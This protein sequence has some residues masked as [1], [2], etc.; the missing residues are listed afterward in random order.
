MDNKNQPAFPVLELKQMGDK[1]LLDC[2]EVG[3]SKLEFFACNAPMDIPSWFEH[4]KPER[5]AINPPLLEN[6]ISESDRKTAEG[7][8]YD[9]IFDLPEHLAW[10]QEQYNKYWAAQRKFHVAN[11]Q[12]R[13]FQWR[14]FY[15]EQLLSELSN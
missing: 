5:E 14:R 4:V 10:F 2:A 7:W 3:V 9:P 8:L 6:I 11:D 15:A 12:A 13:Y 1:L